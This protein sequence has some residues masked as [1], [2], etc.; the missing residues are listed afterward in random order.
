MKVS[1]YNVD[2]LFFY[3]N[4]M[5]DFINVPVRVFPKHQKSPDFVK[6]SIGASVKKDQVQ[7]LIDYLEWVKW[8]EY[9]KIPIQ[10]LETM[11]KATGEMY[12]YI[13]VNIFK[14]VQT[15]EVEPVKSKKE[16]TTLDDIPF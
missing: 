9:P 10:I 15:E 7:D 5:A 11:N 14:P 1:A 2:T 8:E 12:N 13:S 16:E 6:W 4:N 3:K